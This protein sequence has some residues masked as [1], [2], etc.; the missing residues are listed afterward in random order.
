[1][2]HGGACAV[3]TEKDIE[4]IERAFLK[5]QLG[6]KT[7][8][9]ILSVSK[10]MMCGRRIAQRYL[11]CNM[12]CGVKREIDIDKEDRDQNKQY[13]GERIGTRRNNQVVFED[14][15]F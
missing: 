3:I 11:F 2:N 6:E 14:E 1:M 15:V 7:T 8:T 9:T 10:S 12:A 5:K 13:D 4:K